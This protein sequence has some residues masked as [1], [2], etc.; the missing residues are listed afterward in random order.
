MLVCLLPVQY[1]R[2]FL[3]FSLSIFV[4]PFFNIEKPGFHYPSYLFDQTPQ[5][6]LTCSHCPHHMTPARA[7]APTLGLL[8]PPNH[9]Q[10]PAFP[11]E[12]SDTCTSCPPGKHPSHSSWALTACARPPHFRDT[13]SACLSSDAVLCAIAL[14]V[15]PVWTLLPPAETDSLV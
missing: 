13:V 5:M 3:V 7:L 8:P 2:I 10:G 9:V 6:S 14:S 12:G 11:L 15:P 1:H 4:V